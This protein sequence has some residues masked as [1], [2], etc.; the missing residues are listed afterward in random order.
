MRKVIDRVTVTGA[1]DSVSVKDMLPI[2]QEFPFIEWG[3]LLSKS[4]E[5]GRRFPS[6]KWI[7][8]LSEH[9]GE[10]NLSGHLC[11]RW[12]R[13]IC[14]GVDSL[15]V[16]RPVFRG[17]FA[18]YQLNFHSYVHQIKDRDAFLS[19]VR[20]LGAEQVIFQLD[21]VNNDLLSE[22][23]RMNVN[24]VP[25]FD[26]SG[27]AGRL[28]TE[29]PEALSVYSGYAGG[30][31]P[32][33]L[34]EQME[35]IAKK[36]GDDPIW[37]DAETRLRSSHDRVFDLEKV[38]RFLEEAKPWLTTPHG[39]A[40]SEKIS[41]DVYESQE[42]KWIKDKEGNTIHIDGKFND[43]KECP[44]SDGDICPGCG[45]KGL[46]SGYGFAGGYGLGVYNACDKCGLICNFVEDPG[47]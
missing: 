30:L 14:N 39:G 44:R 17:L 46:E 25:L 42:P 45:H 8:K 3:I 18:R 24:A 19:A 22:A 11:G 33:N 5:G 20:N 12:V 7:D 13:D 40:M 32:E 10:L 38:R 9:K 37:I 34:T 28:P 4:Q 41:K 29:W 2:Q 36:C 35:A 26:T 23:Q 31:S 47:D 43:E 27:G 16:D 21:D 15:F 1:D 6:L